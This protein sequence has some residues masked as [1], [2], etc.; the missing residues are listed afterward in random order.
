MF[1]ATRL[2]PVVISAIVMIAVGCGT[3]RPTE[4]YACVAANQAE[5][6][7]RWGTQNDSTNMLEQYS[8]NTKGE[9]FRY[10]GAPATRSDGEFLLVVDGP[11]Y[12]ASAK[13]TMS[14]FLKIQALNTG[15][16]KQRFIDYR[17]TRTD[18]YLR[19]VW[20]PDLQTFQSRDMRELYD[21]LM[22]LV[23][24]D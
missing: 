4:P 5:L 17:N 20:N 3:P 6:M 18:V 24:Q 22:L 14:A 12:C 15:A 13:T 19:A 1:A 16:R 7:I 9:V 23:T 11:T 2:V 21:E 10:V 8:M